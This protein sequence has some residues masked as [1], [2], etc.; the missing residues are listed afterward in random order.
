MSVLFDKAV[1]LNLSSEDSDFKFS[2][3]Y[4]NILQNAK[5]GLHIDFKIIK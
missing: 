2:K 5:K 1:S 4:K 3:Y